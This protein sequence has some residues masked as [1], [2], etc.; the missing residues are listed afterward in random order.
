MRIKFY[1][2]NIFDLDNL[3]P[4]ATVTDDVATSSG[5]EIVNLLR[6]RDDDSGWSTT[7]SNDLGNTTIEINLVDTREFDRI[8][9]LNHNFKSFTLQ[10]WDDL[11]EVWVDFSTVVNP[12]DN[13]ATSNYYEFTKVF[14]SKVK[15]IILGTMTPNDD[16]FMRQFI[17]A[18]AVGQFEVQPQI[19]PVVDRDRQ[20]TKYLSGKTYVAKNA[21]G[22]MVD[23]KMKT[24][25]NENDLALCEK[26]FDSYDGFLVSLSGGTL[27][28][29]ETVRYGYRLQDV[30]LMMPINE[31]EPEW[32]DGRYF[33][34][35]PMNLRLAEIN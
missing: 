30:F 6:N 17:I 19:Q 16:K 33:N 9:L 13:T 18:E 22:F 7:G 35:M 5:Q 12:T 26:L 1:K 25:S 28:Q 34:G 14:S 15:L 23:L 27:T 2:K 24:V 20:S 8:M 3:V 32:N 11:N 4:F 31:Y 29:Y 21:G 10:Y